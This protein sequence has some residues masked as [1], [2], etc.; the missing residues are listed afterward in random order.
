[1]VHCWLSNGKY[2]RFIGHEVVTPSLIF[3]SILPSEKIWSHHLQLSIH[4]IWVFTLVHSWGWGA[5]CLDVWTAFLKNVSGIQR[6]SNLCCRP[7][8][9]SITTSSMLSSFYIKIIL[10]YKIVLFFIL[11]ICICHLSM[12]VWDGGQGWSPSWQYWGWRWRSEKHP[13]QSQSVLQF[14]SDILCS[15]WGILSW[16]NK[17][18]QFSWNTLYITLTS[19]LFVK[20]LW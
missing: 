1:M 13:L 11:W 8:P 9:W 4:F 6:C 18:V 10:K 15:Y 14:F 17:H 20:S 5:L 19:Y 7:C 16:M 2:W 3:C 12:T